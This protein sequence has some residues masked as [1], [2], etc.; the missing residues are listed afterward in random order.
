[1]IQAKKGDVVDVRLSFPVLGH[2]PVHHM[3][4]Q[5][6]NGRA[7]RNEKWPVGRDLIQD[8]SR[9]EEEHALLQ[10][11]ENAGADLL[12]HV[13][14]RKITEDRH[15]SLAKMGRIQHLTRLLRQ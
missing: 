10:V 13:K 11:N 2:L 7:V 8:V 12:R 4:S 1:M 9:S 3:A 14:L 15:D 6:L 5:R